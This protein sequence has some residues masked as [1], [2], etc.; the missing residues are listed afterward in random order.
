MTAETVR[1]PIE[2]SG[3]AKVLLPK[4]GLDMNRVRAELKNPP[5]GIWIEGVFP[6]QDG[7]DIAFRADRK[8]AKPGSQGNLIVELTGG[9]PAAPTDKDQAEKRWS[10]G[11]LPAIPYELA[12]K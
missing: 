11:L 3:C 10:L 2:T 12:E 6:R 7:V 9:R 8:K 5:E 1:I 4:S